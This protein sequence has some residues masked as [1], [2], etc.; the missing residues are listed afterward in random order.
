MN[1]VFFIPADDFS[2][3]DVEAVE[4]TP[5]RN[6]RHEP[7][8]ETETVRMSAEEFAQ[9]WMVVDWMRGKWKMA[10]E[11][12]ALLEVEVLFTPF[13][14]YVMNLEVMQSR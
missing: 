6:E 1:E 12:G 3:L 7:E 10:Q 4:G 2:V 9:T 8:R 13:G 11:I 5:R 14:R